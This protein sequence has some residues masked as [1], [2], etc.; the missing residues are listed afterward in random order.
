MNAKEHFWHSWDKHLSNVCQLPSECIHACPPV[1]PPSSPNANSHM[2]KPRRCLKSWSCNTQC[3]TMRLKTRSISRT[4]TSSPTSPFLSNVSCLSCIESST[5][6]PR[7]G[8]ELSSLPL[9][10]WPPQHPPFMLRLYPFTPAATNVAIPT[11]QVNVQPRDN[12]AM[13][14]AD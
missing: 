8:D 13:P 2:V 3:D 12:P 9:P 5:R 6:R 4:R 1:Y 7:R 10:Q 11:L 14:A